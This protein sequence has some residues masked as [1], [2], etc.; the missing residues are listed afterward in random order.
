MSNKETE[1]VYVPNYKTLQAE[2]ERL[3]FNFYGISRTEAET[4]GA[5][6]IR[7][8]VNEYGDSQLVATWPQHYFL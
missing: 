5:S 7:S 8:E 2:C 4:L 1:L 6:E 3:G